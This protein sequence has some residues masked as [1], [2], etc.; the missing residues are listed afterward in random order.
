MALSEADFVFAANRLGCSVAA[1]KAV[2]KVEAPK[3]AFL[4]DGQVTVL[5]EAHIFDRLT[6]G[7]WRRTH[8]DISSAKWNRALYKGGAAEHQRLQR[9]AALDR[10]AAL[11]S[12][13]WG[14]FQIMGFNWRVCGYRSLQAFINAMQTERGQLDA[15]VGYVRNRGLADELQRRD[16]A[17]FAY[18]YNGA[19]YAENQ[20]DRK[21]AA[22]YKAF[23][24]AP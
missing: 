2:A 5:F 1:V 10:D 11:Q 12:A 21:I 24:G 9:A 19:G 17:G 3:G 13:S 22:A 6:G 20:Y 8:P 23:G 15:F 18:G 4:P 16:W 7:R 14:Q